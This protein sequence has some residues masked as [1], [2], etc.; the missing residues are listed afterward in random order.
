MSKKERGKMGDERGG[1][2]ELVSQESGPR[3]TRVHLGEGAGPGGHPV[4]NPPAHA[5]TNTALRRAG[6]GDTATSPGLLPAV[7][8]QGRD[9]LEPTEL[10]PRIPLLSL[11][12]RAHVSLNGGLEVH[13]AG[14][15]LET[16][17]SESPLST[18]LRP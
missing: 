15:F 17:E 9:R 14:D 8:L 1:K 12:H 16:T 18:S 13:S 10:Q 11:H 2:A 5:T 3:T 4:L 6:G 7:D